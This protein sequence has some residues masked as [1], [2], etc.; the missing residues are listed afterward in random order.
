[1]SRLKISLLAL[2][3]LA[4]PLQAQ[5][6]RPMT[7]IDMIEAPQLSDPQ[8]SPDGKQVLFVMSN[9]TGRP[10]HESRTS[11]ASTRTA[12]VWFK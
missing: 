7:L 10:T 8:V 11:G 4:V 1:M 3:A 2:L 9:P 6:R 5:P 12:A